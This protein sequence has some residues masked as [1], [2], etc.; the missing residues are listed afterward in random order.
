VIGQEQLFLDKA[1]ESLA[2]AQS[3]FANGRYNNCANRCYYACFQAAITALPRAGIR[4]R[5][6]QWSHEFVPG[7]FNGQLIYRRKLYPPQL[8]HILERNYTLRQK[9]DYAEDLVTETEA[10]RALRRT[11]SFVHAIEERGGERA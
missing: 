3:E 4:P 8:R 6:E 2:G 10:N 1:Q 5:G 11:H 7:Q 9:A